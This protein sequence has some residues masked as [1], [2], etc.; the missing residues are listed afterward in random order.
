MILNLK[1][2]MKKNIILVC[3]FALNIIHGPFAIAKPRRAKAQQS[4]PSQASKTSPADAKAEKQQLKNDKNKLIKEDKE[5]EKRKKDM[6]PLQLKDLLEENHQLRLKSEQLD[7]MIKE[8]ELKFKANLEQLNAQ[9]TLQAQGNLALRDLSELPVG[10]YTIDQATG[11]VLIGGMVDER[12]GVDPATGVPFIKGVIF[13]VQIGAK[14]NLNL[15]DVLID[16]VNHE[17]LEQ[18]S[19]NELY[20]YT[21]GH[22]RNYW[23]ADKLKKG[24]RVMGIELAWIVPFK[25]GK[26]VILKE[27]LSTVIEQKGKKGNT[28]KPAEKKSPMK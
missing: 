27:V 7:V 5:W 23:E 18:E 11:R 12:Y 26:R 1:M 14:Q 15:K 21:I 4:S 20:K 10:S 24:L 3:L 28:S 22:F 16:E 6:H 17:N 8:I 2:N 9:N 19:E 25:D 13:K